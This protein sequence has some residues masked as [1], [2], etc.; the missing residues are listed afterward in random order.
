MLQKL[1]L[2]VRIPQVLV[3]LLLL[4]S[5]V[6]GLFK[7]APMPPPAPGVAA[8]FMVALTSTYLLSLVKVVEIGV[9][10]A[11]LTNRFV[12][13]ALV[14]L[15][16]VT[17][18]IVGFHTLIAPGGLGAPMFLL[19]AHLWLAWSHRAAYAPLFRSSV[20]RA[21]LRASGGAPLAA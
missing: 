21:D 19:V 14:V 9:G 20:T 11:L 5:G 2:A 12:P 18:N 15:A 1:N 6:V 3:G 4:V 17:V 8:D 13:L 10:L 7:L 16:P